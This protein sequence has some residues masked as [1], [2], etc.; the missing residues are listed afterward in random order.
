MGQGEHSPQTDT[1]GVLKNPEAAQ[2]F[3]ARIEALGFDVDEYL[4]EVGTKRP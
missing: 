1:A 4:D 2:A 3:F